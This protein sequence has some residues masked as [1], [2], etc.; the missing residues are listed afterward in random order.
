MRDA[1][2]SVETANT[3]A[4]EF[5][6]GYLIEK[7]L[8]VDNIFVF[9]LIFSYFAVPAAYQKR[10]L[11]IGIIGAISRATIM[12]GGRLAAA[13]VP[14]DPVPVRR[15]PDPDRRE[16]VVGLRMRS[17]AWTATPRR[18]CCAASCP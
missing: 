14:L 3:R 11:M 15:L 7:S 2:G 13:A 1:T 9:L 17:R 8:A 6:T 12:T 5:L 10:V 16:D 4:L 18:A